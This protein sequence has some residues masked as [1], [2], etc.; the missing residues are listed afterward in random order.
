MREDAVTAADSPPDRKHLAAM[1]RVFARSGAYF[2]NTARHDLFEY[3]SIAEDTIEAQADML[4]A[5]LTELTS[6][7]RGRAEDAETNGALRLERDRLK[8]E[9]EAL[10]DLLEEAIDAGAWHD[11][12][13]A[14]NIVREALERTQ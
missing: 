11:D 8:T 1:M 6:H 12:G 7:R 4:R 3:V 10:R 5:D 14:I 2:G 13:E 9:I